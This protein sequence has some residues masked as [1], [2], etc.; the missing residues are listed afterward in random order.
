M[1]AGSA[2]P[3][4]R[5]P[6]EEPAEDPQPDPDR[7]GRDDGTD[8][9]DRHRIAER[10]KEPEHAEGHEPERRDEEVPSCHEPERGPDEHRDEDD[11]H[12]EGELVVGPEQAHDEVLGTWRL[13]VDHDLADR[14]HERRRAG[15]QSG[16]QLRDAQR[17]ER[18]DDAGDR[19]R[20]VGPER[21]AAGALD[22]PARWWGSCSRAHHRWSV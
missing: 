21:R 10:G 11:D 14:R 12:L 1:V 4:L 5:G 19:G 13:E 18:R 22:R 8:L 2:P 9:R 15:Q 20:A 6:V 17:D 16:Q 7:D 3:W